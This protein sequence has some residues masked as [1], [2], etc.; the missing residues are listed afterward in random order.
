[1]NAGCANANAAKGFRKSYNKK[2]GMECFLQK[3]VHGYERSYMFSSFEGKL[4]G[5]IEMRKDI[6]T[7]EGKC[8]GVHL[9]PL[10]DH[11]YENLKK[12]C[13]ETKW[14]GGGEI[15][16]MEDVTGK[17][18]CTD[19]NPRFPAWVFGGCHGG[20]NVVG[21]LLQAATGIATDD[22][23]SPTLGGDFIRS[24]IEVPVSNK[25]V[26]PVFMAGPDLSGCRGAVIT[27]SSMGSLNLADN[28]VIAAIS[29][30]SRFGEIAQ[31]S[32]QT[33]SDDEE[34]CDSCESDVLSDVADEETW[35]FDPEEFEKTPQFM[36]DKDTLQS[37]VDS[38]TDFSKKIAKANDVETIVGLSVKTQP[39]DLLLD[40]AR[41]AGWMS[42]CIHQSEVAKS[43]ERGFPSNQIIV[44]GPLK[45]WP[46]QLPT[47]GLKA[48]FA[49]SLEDYDQL[50]QST[51]AEFVGFRLTPH[52]IT[53][54]FGVPIEL[55]KEMKQ[56]LDLL[57]EDQ[58]IG[59]HFHFAQTKIGTKSWFAMARSV[60]RVIKM[61]CSRVEM[62]DFGGGWIPGELVK[63]EKQMNKLVEFAKA[64]CP[65]VKTIVFE[66]GKSVSQSCG[67]FVTQVKMF[68]GPTG[69]QRDMKNPGEFHSEQGIIVDGFIG[70]LG[71]Y[72]LHKHPCFY[73]SSI[74]INNQDIVVRKGRSSDVP[75]IQQALKSLGYSEEKVI[76]DDNLFGYENWIVSV[77]ED[78][79]VGCAFAVDTETCSLNY[80]ECCTL[81]EMVT[82]MLL[83]DRKGLHVLAAYAA[84]SDAYNV[85]FKNLLKAEIKK[86]RNSVYTME[87]NHNEYFESLSFKVEESDDS[88][89]II[90]RRRFWTLLQ[91]GK[92]KILG[93]I[94]MEFDQFGH[95][96]IPKDMKV[97]DHI[98]IRECG[99]YDMTMSYLFGDA[100]QRDIKVLKN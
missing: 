50:I 29:H 96:K 7:K 10:S 67:G 5:A 82:D 89:F 62:L 43:I 60:I 77:F 26:Q 35:V 58:K 6:V 45:N 53:S 42:E 25:L 24:V 65:M 71:V 38:I 1:M 15:E 8:W 73:H 92:D 85:M 14:T 19:F 40:T 18:F 36:M 63:V 48:W 81:G 100:I 55:W 75:F 13:Q 2:W 16:F 28:E 99:A 61:M 22:V 31:L 86:G 74:E 90:S 41:E 72:G 78:Q 47:D 79:V 70:D 76:L 83:S 17:Q 3:P 95:I 4:L 56:R 87:E 34:E 94:C 32:R 88:S 97:G 98:L 57:P 39:H 23:T 91:P 44:N 20:V 27:K 59:I 69:Q 49:D 66:P 68:R 9:E 84:D 51:P 11:V 54:R 30:P 37:V 64:R 93:R 80:N 46:A 21:L 33:E 12:M 52:N